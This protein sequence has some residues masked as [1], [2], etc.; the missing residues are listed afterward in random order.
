M[1]LFI[2]PDPSSLRKIVNTWT[3][4]GFLY[5]QQF[6]IA[7][8][9]L[10]NPPASAS[11]PRNFSASSWWWTLNLSNF[12]RME[13]FCHKMKWGENGLESGRLL[14]L[15]IFHLMSLAAMASCQNFCCIGCFLKPNIVY[16]LMAN[17]SLLLIHSW[18]LKGEYVNTNVTLIQAH[19]TLLLN[20]INAYQIWGC[21]YNLLFLSFTVGELKTLNYELNHYWMN[22]HLTLGE[23]W[24]KSWRVWNDI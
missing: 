23:H 22:N 1:A 9:I 17:W 7:T 12:L 10:T 16:G 3:G 20:H 4:A 21:N 19:Q 11:S 6:L 8:M 24:N 14:N 13:D 18:F 2:Q 15:K 5:F